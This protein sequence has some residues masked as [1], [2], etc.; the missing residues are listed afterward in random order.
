MLLSAKQNEYVYNQM[1]ALS[2]EM[3]I[4]QANIDYRTNLLDKDYEQM[5]VQEQRAYQ[6]SLMAEERAFT[7]AQTAEE[8]K[9]QEELQ[10]R[11]LEQ[12]YAF[13]YGDLNSENPTLQNIA[14]ERAVAGMYKNY[15]VP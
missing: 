2:D 15:P 13:E 10:T 8:R 3:A 14:I 1:D 9:Y 4:L 7:Q 12:K 5:Q 6:E 11:Q